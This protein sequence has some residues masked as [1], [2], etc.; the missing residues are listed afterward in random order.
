MGQDDRIQ[1]GRIVRQWDAVADDLMWTA[2][3][4]PAVDE[5]PGS[6]GDEEE[7]GTGDGIGS[8][9]E[10]DFHACILPSCWVWCAPFRA[11]M[12][13]DRSEGGSQ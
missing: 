2:L 5:Q 3:E 10:V 8:A 12:Y 9:E 13:A 7:L 6:I 4:H 11:M 1:S